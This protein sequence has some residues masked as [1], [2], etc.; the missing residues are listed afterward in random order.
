MPT[1]DIVLTEYPFFGAHHWYL[2]NSEPFF[3]PTSDIGLKDCPFLMP[4]SDIGLTEYPFFGAHHWYLANT[5]PFLC[6]PPI[7]G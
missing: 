1:S 6:Q 7:L 3:V 4:T 5:D 2:A